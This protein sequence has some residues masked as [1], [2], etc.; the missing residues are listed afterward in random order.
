M[1]HPKLDYSH[2]SPEER[3]QLVED[4]WD[5][6]VRDHPAA[7]PVPESHREEIGRRLAQFHRDGE[8]GRPWR[9]AMDRIDREL[10]ERG[11]Q[12]DETKRGG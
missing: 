9:E 10:A 11:G 6:L 1:A 3:L 2:L 12:E 4:L 7:I 8:R 5:S